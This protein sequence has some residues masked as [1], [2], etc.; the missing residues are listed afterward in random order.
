MSESQHPVTDVKEA[1]V[2]I[3]AI[4]NFAINAVQSKHF[5]AAQALALYPK[6]QSGVDGFANVLPQLKDIDGPEAVELI[7]AVAAELGVLPEK[8]KNVLVALAEC[9][10]PVSKV[11]AAF[12]G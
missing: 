7:G 1:A 4:A 5:D 11:V 9:V 6:L 10:Q 8:A 3:A 2:A 12:R